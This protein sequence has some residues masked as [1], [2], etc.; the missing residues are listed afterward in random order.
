MLVIKISVALTIN[1]IVL[2]K[3]IM[4]LSCIKMKLLVYPQKHFQATKY[5]HLSVF[6]NFF[7]EIFNQNIWN[8]KAGK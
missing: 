1:F 7:Y 4:N 6:L 5:K 8:S 2:D 3:I